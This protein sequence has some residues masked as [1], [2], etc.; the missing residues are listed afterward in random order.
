MIF[1]SVSKTIQMH[2]ILGGNI[3]SDRRG[4]IDYF[5]NW[6]PDVAQKQYQKLLW[7]A[8]FYDD[9]I[10]RHFDGLLVR[11]FADLLL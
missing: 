11:R 5:P 6:M 1:Y 8:G 3:S 9:L 7:R 4:L 2:C 10:K